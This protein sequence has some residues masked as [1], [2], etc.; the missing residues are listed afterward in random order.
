VTDEDIDFFR[1]SSAQVYSLGVEHDIAAIGHDLFARIRAIDR[2]G[3]DLILVRGLEQGGLGLA[4]WDRL[5]R[6]AEGQ[7]IEV[8]EA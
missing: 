7:V 8:G 3:V 1:T 6:A 4:I 2:T 5:V